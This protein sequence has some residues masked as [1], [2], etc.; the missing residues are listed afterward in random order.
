M[1][2]RVTAAPQQQPLVSLPWKYRFLPKAWPVKAYL[3]TLL[4]EHC[5]LFSLRALYLNLIR[6]FYMPFNTLL[7]E[8]RDTSVGELHIYRTIHTVL[9]KYVLL[10]CKELQIKK[11]V[12][13]SFFQFSIAW[14]MLKLLDDC[15]IHVQVWKLI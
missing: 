7:I 12:F 2:V 11:K 3:F 13:Y 9:S 8:R 14:G 5:D 1:V 15:S 6:L 10:N 4:Y